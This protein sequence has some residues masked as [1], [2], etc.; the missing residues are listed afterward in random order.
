MR[1]SHSVEIAATPQECFDAMTDFESYPEW[2]G[3][4]KSVQVSDGDVVAFEVDAKVRTIHY[5]LRYHF[6]QPTR[7]WWDYVE[8]DAKS[9]D[10]E[11]TFEDLGDGTTRATYTLEIDPGGFVPGPLK[12]VLSDQV[13]KA[14][15]EDLRRH[16]ER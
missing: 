3:P 14:S 8:G 5:T 9:V 16:L 4:V 11:Y 15:V 10:G 2:Q 7:I 6:D 13:M 12:K 1:A